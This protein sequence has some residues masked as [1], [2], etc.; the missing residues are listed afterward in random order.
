MGLEHYVQWGAAGQAQEAEA[1]ASGKWQE[2]EFL[3]SLAGGPYL[4]FGYGYNHDT[5]L[6]SD[7][8]MAIDSVVRGSRWAEVKAAGEAR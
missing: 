6:W 2:G 8:I 1:V 5:G 4:A 7:R 3:E